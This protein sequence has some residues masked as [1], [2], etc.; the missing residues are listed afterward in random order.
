MNEENIIRNNIMK[1]QNA[2]WEVRV[3][4]GCV[5]ISSFFEEKMW[6][7]DYAR[8][9]MCGKGGPWQKVS[10]QPMLTTWNNTHLL[11]EVTVKPRYAGRW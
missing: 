3:K 4:D 5:V 2:I 1:T 11:G 8:E 6:A 10:N 7:Y 9:Y